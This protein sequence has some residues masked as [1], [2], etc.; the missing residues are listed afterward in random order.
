[1]ARKSATKKPTK[2]PATKKQTQKSEFNVT[3]MASLIRHAHLNG[4]I[5]DAVI[6]VKDN[7]ATIDAIDMSQC[8]FVHAVENIGEAQD[9]KI[10]I[11]RLSVFLK[12]LE[13]ITEDTVKYTIS[14]EENQW[15]KLGIKNRGD[16]RFLLTEPDLI[17]TFID[18]QQFIEKILSAA[19]IQMALNPKSVEDFLYFMHLF[20]SDTV[21]INVKNK[22]VTITPSPDSPQSFDVNFGE[23]EKDIEIEATITGKHIQEIMKG[24]Q[25]GQEGAEAAIVNFSEKA[26]TPLVITQGENRF[27]AVTTD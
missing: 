18:G 1:M 21:V 12:V 24:L 13:A 14:G 10:G 22:A 20:N 27:W 23:L 4:I 8:V 5:D 3:A 15:L 2:K 9:C 25:F 6:T 7:V 17:A 26:Q 11:Q 19:N 16:A